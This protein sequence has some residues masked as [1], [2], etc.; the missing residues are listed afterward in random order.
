VANEE[1]VDVAVEHAPPQPRTARQVLE[2]VLATEVSERSATETIRDTLA[3]PQALP[4]LVRAY[5]QALG[6]ATGLAYVPV[7]V[8]VL[9]EEGGREVVRD[10]ALNVSARLLA[11]A[12]AH[13]QRAERVLVAAA[14][15]VQPDG[16]RSLAQMLVAPSR[17]AP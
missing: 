3:E 12:E 8:A 15:G 13:G 11:N 14:A 6:H 5:D 4:A 10:S 16:E 1:L 9:G 2:E 17:A 7:A